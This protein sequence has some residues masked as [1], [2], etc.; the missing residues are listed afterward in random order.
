V[1]SPN[2][3]FVRVALAD[4]TELVDMVL[5][6]GG[7][8]GSDD[9]TLIDNRLHVAACIVAASVECFGVR[10][11]SGGK[12]SAGHG[13]AQID[14]MYPLAQEAMRSGLYVPNRNS[15][16]CSRKYCPFW[17]Y[18]ESDYGGVVDEQ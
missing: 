12:N 10:R 14:R 18:C 16:L 13:A 8:A 2:S 11:S 9:I 7:E 1:I 5:Q 6:R 4:L 15:N 17:E 3:I